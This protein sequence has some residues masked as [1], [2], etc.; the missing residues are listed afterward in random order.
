MVGILERCYQIQDFIS[1]SNFEI[2]F[3]DLKTGAAVERNIEVI[4]EIVKSLSHEARE[5]YASIPWKQIAGMRDM[6]IHKYNAVDVE[7]VWDVASN[8]VNII[9]E[10][11][12]K[13]LRE[14]HT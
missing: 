3:D 11:I 10:N 9:V 13:I 4:G 14:N 2:F 1:G 12:E 6:L 5:R 7:I 8:K